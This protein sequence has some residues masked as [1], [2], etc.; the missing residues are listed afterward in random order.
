MK[1]W[2]LLISVALALASCTPREHALATL[3]TASTR[4]DQQRLTLEDASTNLDTALAGISGGDPPEAI[5]SA[6]TTAHSQVQSAITDNEALSGALDSATKD[7]AQTRNPEPAI[8]TWMRYGLV[9]IVT[10]AVLYVLIRFVAPV[11]TL[12]LPWLSVFIPKPK[13]DL[14]SL[15]AKVD[16]GTVDPAVLVTAVRSDPHANAAYV[17]AQRKGTTNGQQP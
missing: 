9:A 6:V 3:S 12:L 7:V 13:K 8:L 4:L 5:A 15:A 14:G 16:A 1:T 2:L 17:A 11:W 10:L